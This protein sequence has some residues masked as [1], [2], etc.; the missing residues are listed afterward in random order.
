M[1][2]FSITQ[3][4]LRAKKREGQIKVFFFATKIKFK[5]RGFLGITQKRMVPVGHCNCRYFLL[6]FSR[7]GQIPFISCVD[8][9]V[10][11]S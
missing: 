2:K 6:F 10:L 8:N 4:Q 7:V 1:K 11:V 5:A 3:K 9:F